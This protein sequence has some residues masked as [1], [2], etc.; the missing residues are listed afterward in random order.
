VRKLMV[1]L[2]W[3]WLRNQ[4]DSALAAWF[5]D[6]VQGQSRRMRRMAIPGSSP[7]TGLARKLLIA[8]WRYVNDGVVPEG[9]V[10]KSQRTAG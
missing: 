1:Q 3:L 7:G 6:R 2:A 4:P 5:R 8:L 10:L 9:A